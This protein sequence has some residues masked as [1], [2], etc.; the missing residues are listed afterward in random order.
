MATTDEE[1]KQAIK[2]IVAAKAAKAHAEAIIAEA[3]ELLVKIADREESKTI[4]ASVAGT[5]YSATVVTTERLSYDEDALHQHLGDKKWKK[6]T[7]SKVDPARLKTALT[8]GVLEV[9]E[10]APYTTLKKS[11]PYIRISQKG[12]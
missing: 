3:T 10:V 2:E 6:I 8:E 5:T 1:V 11:S 7:V 12:L 4:E 9:S